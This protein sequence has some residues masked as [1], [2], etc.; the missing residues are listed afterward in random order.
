MPGLC[1]PGSWEGFVQACSRTAPSTQQLCL[2]AGACPPRLSSLILEK[3]EVTAVTAARTC[4][5]PSEPSQN[6]SCT[7]PGGM[8]PSA[9]TLCNTPAR[10]GSS[11]CSQTLSFPP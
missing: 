4:V 5:A 8:S 7:T 6:H 1:S 2:P 3:P 10:E 11:T 9:I